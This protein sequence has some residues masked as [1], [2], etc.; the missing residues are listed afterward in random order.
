MLEK[1]KELISNSIYQELPESNIISML[2]TRS[3]YDT[4][5]QDLDEAIQ[6]GVLKFRY[7]KGEK[8]ISLGKEEIKEDE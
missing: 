7:V 8:Y 3:I 5:R 4:T 6:S 1:I 2:Q